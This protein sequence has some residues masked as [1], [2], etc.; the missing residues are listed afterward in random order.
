MA[1]ALP[2]RWK[3]FDHIQRPRQVL[4]RL[5][6]RGPV[7]RV[8]PGQLEVRDG[9]TRFPALFEVHGEFGGD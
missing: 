4:K 1:I 8:P 6:I 7:H 2:T 3:G 5:R 9:R